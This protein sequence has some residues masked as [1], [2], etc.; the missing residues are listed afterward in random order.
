MAGYVSDVTGLTADDARAYYASHY[1]PG[2]AVLAIAGDFVP[3]QAKAL[4]ARDFADV[5]ARSGGS[6]AS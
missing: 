2:N 6:T 4:V 1:A 5:P 3:A